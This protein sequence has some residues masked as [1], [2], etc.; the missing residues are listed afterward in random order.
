MT[1]AKLEV[2]RQYLHGF[3]GASR[4]AGPWYAID[5]FAGSGLN[6]TKT[7]REV[8]GST[9]TIL[10]AHQEGIA[11]PHPATGVIAIESDAHRCRRLRTRLAP[12]GARAHVLEG[13]HEGHLEAA[14]RLVPR[15]AL[16][17]ALLDPEGFDVAWSTVARLASHRL[18]PSGWKMEQLVLF[19]SA[20]V[21]RLRDPKHHHVL[22]RAFGT[23]EWRAV[24]S[25]RFKRAQEVVDVDL[26]GDET[27]RE[28]HASPDVTAEEAAMAWADLYAGRF[29]STL[30][31]RYAQAIPMGNERGRLRYH[32]IFASDNTVGDKIMSWVGERVPGDP[33][34]LDPDARLIP[35]F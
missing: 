11:E 12:Y 24:L 1:L 4:S 16:S 30:G 27:V 17:F 15:D 10:D 19:P 13:D 5:L 9:R 22:D 35:L 6:V 26:F 33:G 34:A 28:I 3:A 8:P 25:Q 7:G 2:L 23:H 14:L 29:R 21:G 18:H 31:Y 20:W 32:L